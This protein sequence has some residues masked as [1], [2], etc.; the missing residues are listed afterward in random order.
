PRADCRDD[1]RVFRRRRPGLSSSSCKRLLHEHPFSVIAS[2]R[3]NHKRECALG[4]R[5]FRRLR[6]LATTEPLRGARRTPS[7]SRD[8]SSV[9]RSSLI[10][11]PQPPPARCARHLLRLQGRNLKI[12]PPPQR[13]GGGPC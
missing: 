5:L 3:R 11:R 13:G 1:S 10:A 8:F 4:R 7:G 12:A 9:T 6:I 2:E